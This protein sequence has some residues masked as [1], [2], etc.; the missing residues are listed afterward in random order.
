MEERSTVY[1]DCYRGP[2]S[3]NYAQCND[4]FTLFYNQ[5]AL[6]PYDGYRSI[7]QVRSLRAAEQF[8]TAHRDYRLAMNQGLFLEAEKAIRMMEKKGAT[9]GNPVE[10]WRLKLDTVIAAYRSLESLAERKD[11]GDL[12]QIDQQIK[13]L[14]T[15]GQLLKIPVNEERIGKIKAVAKASVEAAP[16]Y[17]EQQQN[18]EELQAM[19]QQ[20]DVNIVEQRLR[21]S[22]ERAG[23]KGISFDQKE[24]DALLEKAKKV[25]KFNKYLAYLSEEV[26]GLMSHVDY[27]NFKINFKNKKDYLEGLLVEAKSLGISEDDKRIKGVREAFDQVEGRAVNYF[28]KYY[29]RQAKLTVQRMTAESATS[30]L[31]TINR[32]FDQTAPY[33]ELMEVLVSAYRKAGRLTRQK[34]I[35]CH[36][37]GHVECAKEFH[38]LADEYAPSAP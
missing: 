24:A 36:Q 21:E 27:E 17:K 1:T 34:A 16:A 10:A 19:A 5:L 37:Q 26:Q 32:H 11:L 28:P 22:K 15:L 2:G 35:R 18:F 20:G 30:D 29:L 33:D 13:Q 31:L 3:K 7:K 23:Q 8:Y 9:A 6:G 25:E 4:E 38:K 12:N 14:R